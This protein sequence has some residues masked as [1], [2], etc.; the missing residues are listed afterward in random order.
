[1]S[2]GLFERAEEAAAVLRA[3]I[4][5][6]PAAAVVLG[7]GLA[8]FVDGLG[9][10]VE[11]AYDEVPHLP[12][13]TVEGHRGKLVVGSVGPVRIAALAGRSH[14]YEGHDLD[15][16]TLPVR[17]LQRLGVRLLV[18]TAAV[19]AV[20]PTLRPGGLVCLSDHINLMGAN[21]LRGPHDERL[22]PRFPDLS[23]VY[24]P[25]L[26]AIARQAASRLG[27]ALDEGVYA[28][29]SGPTY[30]TP[31]EI[32]MLAALGADVVGMSTVP[33]AIV[34]RHAGM[35]VLG[36]AL[37]T[38]WAAGLAETPISHE[39]VLQAGREAAPRL[40]ALLREVFPNV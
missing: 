7:S 14:W 24:S 33:E 2:P 36:L 16:V 27:I 23:A 10:P 28:A 3:R 21:P 39:E 31:A 19:G 5:P 13:P 17:V 38:N 29:V 37:V 20:R 4:A 6:F 18:L 40:T 1:M 11:V 34:A 30:E 35:E 22:G 8:S 25:R 9:D 32:R 26:R 12:R 15:T